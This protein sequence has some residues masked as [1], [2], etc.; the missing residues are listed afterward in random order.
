MEKTWFKLST[1]AT[2]AGLNVATVRGWIGKGWVFPEETR[3]AYKAGATHY[4][5]EDGARRLAIMGRLQRLGIPGLRAFHAS[6]MFLDVG[7][8]M[9]SDNRGE[10][11]SPRGYPARQPGDLF[12]EGQTFLVCPPGDEVSYVIN[13]R[14]GE[15]LGT[16]LINSSNR[17]RIDTAAIVHLNAVIQE[18]DERLEIAR[19]SP[20]DADE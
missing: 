1:A 2:A 13:V 18:I 15:D 17:A 12:P 10:P 6:A 8:M 16:A 20:D 5:D 9:V 11:E 3:L 7:E 4:I 19:Q 14:P